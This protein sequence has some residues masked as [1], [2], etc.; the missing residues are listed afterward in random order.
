[1][2]HCNY[3]AKKHLGDPRRSGG[4]TV[5][6]LVSHQGSLF[7]GLGYHHDKRN[8]WY[9]GGNPKVGWGRVMRLDAVH[10]EWEDDLLLP[11]K[12]LRA[13]ALGSVRFA[14]DGKGAPLEAPVSLL[15]CATYSPKFKTANINVF[16]RDDEAGSW[17]CETLLTVDLPEVHEDLS[18]RVVAGHRDRET[19]VDMVFLG[20]GQL[21]I[22]AGTYDR[23][24][25]GKICWRHEF[26]PLESR[27]LNLISG[28][29]GLYVSTKSKILLRRD[30]E[31][32]QYMEVYDGSHLVAEEFG[33]GWGGVRGLLPL[34]I[35]G[36]GEESL[37]FAYATGVRSEMKVYQMVCSE[38]QEPRLFEEVCLRDE[39]AAFLGCETLGWVMGAWNTPLALMD[40]ETGEEVH[41]IGL[42]SFVT[43]KESALP[44]RLVGYEGKD[45]DGFSSGGIYCGSV[46]AIRR[47]G[48]AYRLRQMEFSDDG[49][50]PCPI[51]PYSFAL[52]PFVDEATGSPYI[53]AGGTDS[54]PEDSTD[55]AWIASAP[56]RD[57]LF[58]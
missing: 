36:E 58:S 6:H 5:L 17:E 11:S 1:M 16:V 28:H 23:E 13:E 31:N 21:G 51:A 18:I 7:A 19:G 45:A 56:L 35:S 12:H 24:C 26:G 50:P 55:L 34:G 9:G 47:A 20:A 40:P 2:W 52:S 38:V 49:A 48:G 33:Q 4:S 3:G 27:P 54:I 53:F 30:G 10:G 25:P 32:P 29:R 44:R 39:M 41:L 14:T 42:E 8:I 57:V 22:F 46:Y 15:L 43:G 37:L